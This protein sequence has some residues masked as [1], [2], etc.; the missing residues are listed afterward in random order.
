MN[1]ATRM[2]NTHEGQGS[3]LGDSF[4]RLAWSNLAAQAAEQ[5]ALAAAP[6]IAVL[7]LAA[8]TGETGLLQMA[9]SLPFLF[10]SLP[11]GVLADRASR[12]RLMIAA[13]G[14]RALA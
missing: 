4:R 14:V 11:A 10:L 5:V 12:R 6:M 9:Q 1:N 7:S 13:E 8:G 2:V 3:V